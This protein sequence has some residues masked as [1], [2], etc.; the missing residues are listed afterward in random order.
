MDDFRG[1][2]AVVTGA[3]SGIGLALAERFASE[4][5][6]VVLGD[7]ESTALDE[8][9]RALRAAGATTL[10]VQVDVADALQVEAL[11]ERA[12]STF[13]AVHVLCNNAGVGGEP[14]PV[15]S[16]SLDDWRWLLGVNLMGVVHGVHA[17]VPR[18]AKQPFESWVINTASIAGLLTPPPMLGAY[19]VTKHA[20]VALSESLFQDLAT[21]RAPVEVAVLCPA[22]VRTR[23]ADSERNRRGA[24][25]VSETDAARA[26]RA[27]IEGGTAA[28][29]VAEAVLG[30]MREHR[31][32]VLP[33]P[34]LMPG[35][36]K[37]FRE[38]ASGRPGVRRPA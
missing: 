13:G 10:A 4:G 2:T 32:Y 20:V 12:F 31:F 1:K 27:L 17:F 26:L 24:A 36:D 30:A 38:I 18:M 11:A 15:F 21:V 7:V 33:H 28:S 35:V 3:A 25:P 34:E 8:A 6:Q 29:D 37:R 9:D 5:M 19:A 22:W 16:Y 23:L 14:K